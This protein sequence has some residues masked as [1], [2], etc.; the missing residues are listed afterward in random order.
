MFF[1]LLYKNLYIKFVFSHSLLFFVFQLLVIKSLM[2]WFVTPR[3]KGLDFAVRLN[4]YLAHN[5][6]IPS[7]NFSYLHISHHLNPDWR[8]SKQNLFRVILFLFIFNRPIFATSDG[9]S[10]KMYNTLVLLFKKSNANL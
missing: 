4:F 10:S 2:P 7:V 5:S 8:C 3:T 9:Q 1:G 6:L